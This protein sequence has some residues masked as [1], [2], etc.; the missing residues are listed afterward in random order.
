MPLGFTRLALAEEE[1][2][3]A[4]HLVQLPGIVPGWLHWAM[5][6]RLACAWALLRAVLTVA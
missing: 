5:R 4:A 2:K 6:R 3:V 1:L